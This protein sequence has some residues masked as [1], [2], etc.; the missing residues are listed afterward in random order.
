[1]M[2]DCHCPCCCRFE[3][4]SANEA[5]GHR[6]QT[7]ICFC[8]NPRNWKRICAFLPP[9]KA[10]GTFADSISSSRELRGYK[11]TYENEINSNRDPYQELEPIWTKPWIILNNSHF[12]EGLFTMLCVSCVII[13]RSRISKQNFQITLT[14]SL[15]SWYG[16]VKV[17]SRKCA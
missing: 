17:P 11:C 16:S 3:R 1:M 7:E 10:L 5:S 12:K 14:F 8:T 6:K 15:A 9:E 2:R 4:L 13:L